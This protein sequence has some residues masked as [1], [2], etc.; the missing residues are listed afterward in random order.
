MNLKITWLLT[1]SLFLAFTVE[2]ETIEKSLAKAGVLYF[3]E[4]DTKHNV[5]A[6]EE[7]IKIMEQLQKENSQNGL[8]K[9]LLGRLYIRKGK[10]SFWFW[11]KNEWAHKGL[12]LMD[13]AVAENPNHVIILYERAL[14]TCQLPS[15]FKRWHTARDDFDILKTLLKNNEAEAI[16]KDWQL[17]QSF[18]T[19]FLKN[20]KN[21]QEKLIC[22]NQ[23]VYYYSGIIHYKLRDYATSKN[24]MNQ[25]IAFDPNSSYGLYAFLWLNTTVFK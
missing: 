25:V 19:A 3:V 14:Y 2:A 23:R 16:L 15:Y 6:F 20:I 9:V 11:N 10:E 18:N 21:D 7:S 1:L 17:W 5:L 4:F 8:I 13:E 24:M 22:I 12:S